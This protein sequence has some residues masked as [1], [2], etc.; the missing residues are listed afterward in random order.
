MFAPTTGSTRWR[1]PRRAIRRRSK[2]C[3]RLCCISPSGWPRR[4]RPGTR[5]LICIYMWSSKRSAS[6]GFPHR[7]AA[8]KA[9]PTGMLV[10]SRPP[11][12]TPTHNV[13]Q[14]PS[15]PQHCRWGVGWGRGSPARPC[16]GSARASLRI[17]SFAIVPRSLHATP[18]TT[19]TV[20]EKAE[21]F[22]YL[23]G[24]YDESAQAGNPVLATPPC[25]KVHQS[26]KKQVKL[27]HSQPFTQS[28]QA[29]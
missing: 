2:K 28:G 8:R 3:W 22:R 14:E 21:L 23:G 4:C 11:P 6:L 27:A 18:S 9:S 17:D 26:E 5:R 19:C 15:G 20:Q 29:I 12:G 1:I 7:R 10:A 13:G 16:R 24:V 25:Q